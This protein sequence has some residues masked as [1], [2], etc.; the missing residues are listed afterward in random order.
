MPPF[1][2]EHVGSLLRPIELTR[3]FRSFTAGEISA[4]VF[5]EVQDKVLREVVALQE[6]LGLKAVT[7]GEFRRASYWGHW[8]DAID[9]LDV[10][11][12]F[13]TFHDGCG[14]EQEFIA[15]TCTGPLKQTAPISTGE[16]AYLHSV[17]KATPK[18]TLP[19]PSTLHF[20][21]LDQTITGSAYTTDEAYLADLTAIYRQEIAALYDLG[22]RYVQL[23]EVPLI[24]LANPEIRARVT[25]FGA[26]PARLISLYIESLNP[27]LADR[28]PDMTAALHICRGNFKGKWL[29]EGGYD[30]IAEAVFQSVD[31]DGF[32]LE[33][34]TQRAGGLEVLH[35]VPAGKRVVLGLGSS[36]IPQLEDLSVIRKRVEEATRYRPLESLSISPQCGFASTVAGNPVTEEDQIEKLAALVQLAGEIWES[37]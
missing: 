30:E 1:R 12:S 29:T 31:V 25:A 10:A 9:G 20:W 23:D 8:V 22:C 2:A 3:A 5:E 33:F 15:A 6:A 26:D 32:F 35:H 18:I 17:A 7:D 27:A 19:S 24:M 21:R 14:A 34:D 16:F 28:P 37:D 11:P 36:K 4:E 13:F